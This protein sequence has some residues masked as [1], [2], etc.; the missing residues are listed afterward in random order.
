MM[1]RFRTRLWTG[2]LLLT[3]MMTLTATGLPGRAAQPDT[4][5]ASLKMTPASVG[6]Y[7]A[8]LRNREQVAAIAKSRAWAKLM[9][10]P[11]VKQAWEMAEPQV[12]TYLEVPQ[13]KEIIDLVGDMFSDEIFCVGGENWGDFLELYFRVNSASN[14]GPLKV[15]AQGKGNIE[16]YNQLRGKAVVNVLV[17]HNKLL[18]IPDTVF[19]FHVADAKNARAQLKKLDD[20][21]NGVAVLY[22][23][24]QNFYKREQIGEATFLGLNFSGSMVP[25]GLIPW[26]QAGL[27]EEQSQKLIKILSDLKLSIHLGV[28]GNYVLLNIGGSTQLLEK[29][30]G[31]GKSLLDVPELAPL[32]KDLDRR[33]VSI[34]YTSKNVRQR[35]GTP[36]E[37]MDEMK[38][39]VKGFVEQSSLDA[40]QKLK[41]L[42]EINDQVETF[43]KVLPE[44][45]ASLSYSFRTPKG[46][47]AYSYDYGKFP[48][49]AQPK[50]LTLLDHLGGSPLL[51]AVGRADIN[52]DNYKN[53]TRFVETVWPSADEVIKAK[54]PAEARDKYTQVVQVVVPLVKR[55]DMITRTL[56]LPSLGDGQA[57]LAID[58]KLTTTVWPKGMPKPAQ[59][60]P[61]PEV[62][63]VLSISDPELFIKAL[64]DYRKLFDEA[65]RK[66][67]ELAPDADIPDLK[68]PEA[69]MGKKGTDTLYTYPLPEDLGLDKRIMPVLAVGKTVAAFALSPE[70]AERLLAKKPLQVG[71][72]ALADPNKPLLSASVFDWAGLLNAALPWIEYGITAAAAQDGGEKQVKEIM[73]QVKTVVQVLQV[74]KGTTSATYPE[75]GR[76]VTHSVSIIRDLEK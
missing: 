18:K 76:V 55:L 4:A 52:L 16:D 14:Y 19:G 60:L 23:Q 38:A 56:F 3:G 75:P 63:L 11:A 72:T 35:L 70:H 67:K 36:G 6:F 31:K 13:F 27:E 24:L 9:S 28:Q 7:S 58:A 12:K 34:G 41:V 45:G 64:G 49:Q 44:L 53:M 21:V 20:L 69:K 65:I 15:I 68:F 46:H 10:V 66:V 51:A 42:K 48:E 61:V 62:G 2:V 33:V 54:L 30:G 47:E 5:P 25:W 17:E 59:P 40:G 43:K 73:D 39:V 50:R 22:P 26:G 71:D 29:L 1:H 8:L 37:D 74:Y 32:L 57:G